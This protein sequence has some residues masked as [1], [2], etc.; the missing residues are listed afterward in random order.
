MLNIGGRA[1]TALPMQIVWTDWEGRD[2]TDV[3]ACL[4]G[5][6]LEP[7]NMSLTVAPTALKLAGAEQLN[8]VVA[9]LASG[10]LPQLLP[11]GGSTALFTSSMYRGGPRL[12]ARELKHALATH[13]DSLLPLPSCIHVPQLAARRLRVALSNIIGMITGSTN[14]GAGGGEL[15]DF[16]G[17]LTTLANVHVK[18]EH[19]TNAKHPELCVGIGESSFAMRSAGFGGASS[20]ASVTPDHIWV[21]TAVQEADGMCNDA[22]LS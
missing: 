12:T 2:P 4:S 3:A 11:Q 9:S 20:L 5:A 8:E 16:R 15:A 21:Y 6:L 7:S 1:A 17:E 10:M 19:A 18:V 13:Y 14:T 22:P